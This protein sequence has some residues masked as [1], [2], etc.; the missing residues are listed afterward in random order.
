MRASLLHELS[1]EEVNGLPKARVN[2][3]AL[4]REVGAIIE[5]AQSEQAAA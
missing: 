3:K 2:A 5:A 1:E 4:L